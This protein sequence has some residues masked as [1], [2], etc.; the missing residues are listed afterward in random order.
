MSERVYS[1]LRRR[2]AGCGR[3]VTFAWNTNVGGAPIWRCDT[4][5]PGGLTAEQTAARVAAKETS[6]M[7]ST[8]KTCP[9]V[10]D[11][12][13]V[14]VAA[15]DAPADEATFGKNAARKDGLGRV[16]KSCWS[17]YTAIL[18]AR[19]G[20]ATVG[21]QIVDAVMAAETQPKYADVL[22]EQIATLSI[23]PAGWTTETIA[24]VI[25]A[26]PTDKTTV[27]TTDGQ[28]ALALIA[29][30]KKAAKRARDREYQRQKYAAEK[31]A[32]ANA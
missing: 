32:K 20:G 6:D 2:C 17:R 16:C 23:P 11:G 19:K 27:E 18:K 30:G 25:Y 15:H 7:A 1:R 29:E 14:I 22:A 10:K 21:E 4:C 8:T 12:Q 26:V 31:A 28:A 5:R 9:G 13:T 3:V 24:G